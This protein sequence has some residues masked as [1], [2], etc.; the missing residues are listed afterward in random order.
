MG[1]TID[2]GEQFERVLRFDRSLLPPGIFLLG[3]IALVAGFLLGTE[4][5]LTAGVLSES[6]AT[7]II[8][9]LAAFGPMA[10]LAYAVLRWE[11]IQ[12][13]AVGFKRR[14]LIPGLAL[15]TAVWLGAHLLTILLQVV[16]GGALGLGIPPAITPADW[17]TSIVAQLLV[18]GVVEEFAFRGYFQNK[19]VALFGG[20][21][22]RRRKA[23]AI[24]AATVI[25]AMF[26]VPQRL[27]VQG[28]PLE[29]LPPMLLFLFVYGCFFGVMYE[30]TRN[31]LFTGVLH[32]TFNFQPILLAG[33]QGQP[34][35]DV[36][37]F[38]IPLAAVAIWG[39][40]RWAKRTHPDDFRTQLLR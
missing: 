12:P 16:T 28:A 33:P 3:G 1:S 31:L 17:I 25:F 14:H 9:A 7:R 5:L 21:R 6:P 19:I 27:I 29:S 36:T 4:W 22:D 34:D 24:V 15:V 32:G 11:G 39:Y 38:V 35:L 13:T 18:V 30:L 20:G 40:R 23:A 37:L 2:A 8:F 10:V 26:H